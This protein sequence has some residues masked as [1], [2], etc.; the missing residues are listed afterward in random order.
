LTMVVLKPERSDVIRTRRHP[1]IY[2]GAVLSASEEAIRGDLVPVAEAGGN[3][4]GWGF[5]SPTSLIALRVLCF[6]SK[7]P[8]EHWLEH[9]LQ[10]ALALRQSLA[11][12]SNAYR[13]VNAEGDGLPGLIVDV[14]NRTV[15]VRPLIR[16][17]VVMLDRIVVA[18]QA[19]FPEWAIYLKRDERSSRLEGLDLKNGY[20][21][22]GGEGTE[23]IEEGEVHLLVDIEGGQ[24]T[25]YYLDQRDNRKLARDQASGHSVLN[26]FAY[27]G[28][29]SLQAA[30]GDASEV[31]SVESSKRAGEIFRQSLGLNPRLSS[32]RLTWIEG[33]AFVHLQSC[34]QFDLI[35]AD[36]P[37][38]ARRKSELS[39]ALRGY[40]ELN[41]LAMA[42]TVP[43]GKLMSF[44]CS[45]AVLR[46]DF[47]NVLREASRRAGRY[48][49]LL[50]ELH[51]ASDH[52]VLLGHPEGEY[53]RGWLLRVL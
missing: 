13:L 40:T 8:E 39:G 38:F 41:Q 3:V 49:Q 1:W 36:P 4:L 25:G 34:G 18:L 29:F 10:A 22:G 12:D 17:T 19:L 46:E 27:T 7:A 31:I 52:P 16:S 23:I 5:Y 30:A 50:Q 33:D 37:P 32:A 53:L 44:T 20:L 51:A 21:A 11:I 45:G 43:G 9:R 26:L 2:S 47:L 28:A 35:V 42:R 15:V 6:G 24:K 48:V 14:Y